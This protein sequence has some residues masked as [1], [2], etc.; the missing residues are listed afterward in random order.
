MQADGYLQPLL[1]VVPRCVTGRGTG[2]PFNLACDWTNLSKPQSV[3][4]KAR[5]LTDLSGTLVVVWMESQID[6][7]ENESE[8]RLQKDALFSLIQSYLYTH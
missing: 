2:E 6:V 3:T 1:F 7:E 8:V 4:D 5:W